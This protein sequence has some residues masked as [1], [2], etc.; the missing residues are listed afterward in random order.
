MGCLPPQAKGMLRKCV[1]CD[2]WYPERD[3]RILKL[4]GKWVCRWDA[5]TLTEDER[6][7]A[8]KR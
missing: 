5:D 7:N 8:I 3:S 1:I 4:R 6:Q 2:V